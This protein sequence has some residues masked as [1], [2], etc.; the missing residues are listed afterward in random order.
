[1]KKYRCNEKLETKYRKKS[2]PVS[3]RELGTKECLSE[4]NTKEGEH[5]RERERERER[6]RCNERRVKRT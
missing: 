2:K 5:T 3:K 1:V 6:E 4:E